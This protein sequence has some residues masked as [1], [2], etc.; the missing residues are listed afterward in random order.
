L[1]S[2]GISETGK[3]TGKACAKIYYVHPTFTGPINDILLY[4]LLSFLY[5][6]I[7]YKDIELF[8]AGANSTATVEGERRKRQSH[9]VNIHSRQG[10]GM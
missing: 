9:A 7:R 3:E 2:K 4:F 1:S 5:P 8:Q 6:S 10:F